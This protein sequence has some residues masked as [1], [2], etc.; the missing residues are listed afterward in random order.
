MYICS[1]NN[2]SNK[3]LH[4]DRRKKV[5]FYIFIDDWI[6]NDE[7]KVMENVRRV[8]VYVDDDGDDDHCLFSMMIIS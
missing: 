3:K 1:Y 2:V 8:F 4:I 7:K 5:F 6:G